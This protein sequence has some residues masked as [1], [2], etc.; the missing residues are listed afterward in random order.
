LAE[1]RRRIDGLIRAIE[2][3][4]YEPSMK[5][6]M[7]ALERRLLEAELATAA[8]PKPR[9]HPG[10]ADIY[11]E[12]ATTLQEPLAAED[13]LEMREAIRAL[14]EAIV[15]VPEDGRLAIEVRADLAA[16]LALGSGSRA[17]A[18]ASCSGSTVKLVAGARLSLRRTSH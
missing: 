5:V 3:G 8:E 9:L 10:L 14:V 6:H 13:G 18:F 1:A 2:E 17:E 4:R 11:R 12:K 16:M 7:Q 15:L